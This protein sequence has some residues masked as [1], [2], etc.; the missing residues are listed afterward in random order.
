MTRNKLRQK[1]KRLGVE[2]HEVA[3]K[4]CKGAGKFLR[5]EPL[6]LQRLREKHGV[7]I[8][9]FAKAAKT[10]PSMIKRVEQADPEKGQPCPE[11]ILLAYLEI[12]EQEWAPRGGKKADPSGLSGLTFI[13]QRAILAQRKAD[14]ERRK[15]AREPEEHVKRGDTWEKGD[16]RYEVLQVLRDPETDGNPTVLLKALDRDGARPFTARAS[17]VVEKYRKVEAAA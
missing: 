14:R 3:C 16:T 7:S 1:A 2:C 4:A 8:Y 17:A 5:P 9:A 10:H 15:A 13:E 12:P 11:R 6:D